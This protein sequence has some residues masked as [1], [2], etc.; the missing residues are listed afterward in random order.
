VT[1]RE[2][3]RYVLVVLANGDLR[4]VRALQDELV[5]ALARAP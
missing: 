1:G 5:L 4:G 3:G 2:G